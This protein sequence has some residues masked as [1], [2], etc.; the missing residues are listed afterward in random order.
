MAPSSEKKQLMKVKAGEDLPEVTS[1]K[2]K[3]TNRTLKDT[4]PAV[5][6][7]I[8]SQYKC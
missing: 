3:K 6:A 5:P 1:K 7:I 8:Y 4:L 2:N